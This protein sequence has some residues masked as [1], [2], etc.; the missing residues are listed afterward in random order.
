[1]GSGLGAKFFEFAFEFGG[2]FFEFEE[3]HGGGQ[4]IQD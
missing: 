2:G 3:L 1:L 4:E